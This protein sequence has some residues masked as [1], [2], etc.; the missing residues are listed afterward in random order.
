MIRFECDYLEGAHPRIME[1][2]AAS[3]FQQTPGYGEDE[4][5]E[6]ARAK[7]RAALGDPSANVHFLV[8]GTQANLTLIS[9]AL[10]PW[11]GVIC[12]DT[13]HIAV[14][15]TGA[16]EATGHKVLPLANANGKISAEQ[17][18]KCVDE[19]F[20]DST[21]EHMVQPAMVY[22]SQSTETGTLYSLYE[23]TEIRRVTKE[24]GLLLYIDGARL[25]YAL[26]SEENDVTLPDLA[27]LADAFYIGGTKVGALFGEAMVIENPSLN[28]DFRYMIKQRGG[29]LAKGRLL[30]I[31]FDA[32]FTDDLYARVSRH[33]IRLASR[34][35]EALREAGYDFFAASPTNQLFPIFTNKEYAR[36]SETYS[37][38]Y[39]ARVDEDRVAVRICTSWATTEENVERLITDLKALRA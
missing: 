6:R 17:I 28:R 7:I 14:H 19:H 16:I 11:Q 18:A 8:G 3:N 36:L 9:A 23:L 1:A 22:L 13:G 33:A 38:S 24:K 4:Y 37:F 5:C 30:G 39:W 26:A 10:R 34:V 21:H 32:L 2:L 35:R 29:M 31:Q 20:A 27:R 25:G 15:E 12:A